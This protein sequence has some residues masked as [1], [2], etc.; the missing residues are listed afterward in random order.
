MDCYRRQSSTFRPSIGFCGGRS[1]TTRSL[2]THGPNRTVTILLPGRI[3]RPPGVRR[4]SVRMSSGELGPFAEGGMI[5]TEQ[6]TAGKNVR[7]HFAHTGEES[8]KAPRSLTRWGPL[9]SCYGNN[10]KVVQ[11]AV[12]PRIVRHERHGENQRR[13]CNPGVG[14]T[15]RASLLHA[16]VPN[17]GPSG[18]QQAV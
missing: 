16:L 15:D 10:L 12:V 17:G 4:H 18:A 11:M 13:G 2:G 1:I 14:R 3:L 6:L 8:Q 5:R 7:K 9:T